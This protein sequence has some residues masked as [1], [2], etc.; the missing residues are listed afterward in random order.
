MIED[1]WCVYLTRPY[2]IADGRLFFSGWQYVLHAITSLKFDATKRCSL[3]A[4]H[5][6]PSPPQSQG[7]YMC[8][9][10]LI[11]DHV[12]NLAEHGHVPDVPSSQALILPPCFEVSHLSSC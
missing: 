4:H 2:L 5:C 8:R 12:I 9:S 11:P 6:L 10:E 1:L 7:S 3:G